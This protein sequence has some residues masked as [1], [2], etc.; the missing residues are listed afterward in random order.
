MEYVLN[1]PARR[2]FMMLEAA[3]DIKSFEFATLCDIAAIP[4]CKPEYHKNLKD[5]FLHKT[6]RSGTVKIADN[7]NAPNPL[8]EMF[9]R[10][11]RG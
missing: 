5:Q 1:M 3:R 11:A 4:L 7:P 9:K 8:V 10:G 6:K 2:F